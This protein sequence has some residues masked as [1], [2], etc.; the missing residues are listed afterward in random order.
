VKQQQRPPLPYLAPRDLDAV[1][2]LETIVRNHM[3]HLCLYE[4]DLALLPRAFR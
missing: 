2:G 1:G 3:L 4:F